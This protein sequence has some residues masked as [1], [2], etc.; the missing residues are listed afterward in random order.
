MTLESAP[1]PSGLQATERS[2]TFAPSVV[3]TLSRDT[4]CVPTLLTVTRNATSS[5]GW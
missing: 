4:S 3:E 2:W 5:P 1:K